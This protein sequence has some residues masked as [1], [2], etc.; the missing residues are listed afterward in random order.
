MTT[1]TANNQHTRR[2]RAIYTGLHPFLDENQL[3]EALILWETKYAHQETFSVRYYVADLIKDLNC[4]IQ[5]RHLLVNLVS[6]LAEPDT[7]LLPDP[8]AKLNNYKRTNA[9]AERA[10]FSLA[11][12]EAFQLLMRKWLSLVPPTTRNDVSKFVGRN[13]HELDIE[14]ALKIQIKEWLEHRDYRIKLSQ[15]Y[16]SE[17]RKIINLF[18]ISF[19]EYLGP[20][21]TDKLLAETLK[22][23]KLNGGASYATLFHK[24]L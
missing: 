24:M 14:P 21:K 8:S 10:N 6:T 4:E 19:C 1:H 7:K 15:V 18:Y 3:M 22:T 2:K 13:L 11:E 5:S 17:L 9:V 20:V 16:L 12:L 23:L